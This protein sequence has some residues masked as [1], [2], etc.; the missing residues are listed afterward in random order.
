M[1]II[2]RKPIRYDLG[3]VC[4]KDLDEDLEEDEYFGFIVDA[5]MGCILD[6][7]TRFPKVK[8]SV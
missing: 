8:D 2:D 1:T 5:G 7:K 4:N 3:M 6:V